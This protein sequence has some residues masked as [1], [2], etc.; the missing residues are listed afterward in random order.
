MSERRDSFT[1]TTS[2]EQLEQE[3]K[4]FLNKVG[5]I[6]GVQGLTVKNMARFGD[7]VMVQNFHN[8]LTPELKENFKKI[9]E[10]FEM[11]VD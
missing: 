8:L 3:N 2:W 10:L 4:E 11:N 5:E 9:E 1:T 6:S 7:N